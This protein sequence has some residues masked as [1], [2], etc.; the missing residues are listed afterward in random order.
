MRVRALV[1][2][3]VI[4]PAAARAQEPAVPLDTVQVTAASRA[5]AELVTA[6]RG[7]EVITAA[8]IRTLPARTVAEVLEWAMGVDVT[9]R[10]PAL[11]DIAIRGGSFEQVLVMVDGVRASDAQTGHF[12]MNLA[13]PLDQIERIEIVRGPSSALYGADAVGGV[14]HIVTRREGGGVRARTEAGTWDTRTAALSW[15]GTAGR[16]RADVGG[17]YARSD[18]HRSGTDYE[19]GSGRAALSAP[20]G[21]WT[22]R[23]D[24]AHAARDFGAEGFYGAFPSFERTRTTTAS[25]GMRRAPEV[26]FAIEPTVSFRRHGDDYLLRRNEPE[27][28]RNQ[29]TNLRWGGELMG[30]WRAPAGVRLA[31]GGEWYSDELR[32]ARLGDRAEQHA[33][34]LVEA[35]LGQVGRV[36]ATAGARADWHERYGSVWS[37]SAALAWWP[38]HGIRVRA[39]AGRA[40]RAPTWTERYYQDPA[41]I[42]SPDL[43]PE[44][45]W[46]AEVGANAFVARG[47][48]FGAAAFVRQADQLIDWAKPASSPDEPWRTRNV[49][50]ARFRGVEAEA[51]WDGPLDVVWSATG[52]WLSFSTGAAEGFVSKSAL[53]PIVENVSVG[54]RRVFADR[55]TLSVLGRHARR[56]G[57]DAYLRLDARAAYRIRGV[58]LYADLQ[59]AADE[60]YADITRLSAPGRALFVGLEWSSGR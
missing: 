29:H 57:E 52:S 43:K 37:P 11:A 22:I 17:E 56:T 51:A 58:R 26:V 53:R 59:N 28:Y 42:G 34:G 47:L 50:D 12:D 24:G 55:L 46:S 33:A 45:S 54:A 9:P 48:R 60:Q 20:V 1:A 6:T 44:Q 3:A 39:S 27:G 30:R 8:Q 40:F 14:I 31:G 7:T 4:V 49:Q 32:S 2:V 23:A 25:L 21:K 18:G 41:N 5:A 36:A 38:A 35:A 19:M 13:V 16:V 10:S 15:A